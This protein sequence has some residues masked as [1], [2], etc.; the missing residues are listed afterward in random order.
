V[1]LVGFPR[2]GTTLLEVV[3]DGHPGV[4]SLEEHE[5]LGAGVLRYMREPLDFGALTR[6]SETDLAAVRAAY[7]DGVQRAG[8]DPAGKVFIDKHP[9]NT[10]KLP[11]IARLFPRAKI[12]FALRDPRDVVLS[13]FRRR[14]KMNPA[15]YEL[16]TLAGAAAFYGA[17]MEFAETARSMLG[18]DWRS[19]RYEALMADF[20]GEMRNL[21]EFLSISW[22]DELL[23]FADRAREREHATPSTAQLARGLNLSS[24][25]QWRHYAIHLQ[26]V[27]PVLEPWLQRFGY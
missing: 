15:M 21:C 24:S 18:L 22:S 4:V 12:L 19:V 23:R 11:L 8:V 25:G 17:V 3:L 5:L 26:A 14:F 27:L 6:A 16:L 1:F 20:E 10:L 2:S 9:L 7:W 13:C